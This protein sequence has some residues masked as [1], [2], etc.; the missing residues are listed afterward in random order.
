MRSPRYNLSHNDVE[1]W[2]GRVLPSRQARLRLYVNFIIYN[3]SQTWLSE[4]V[5]PPQFGVIVVTTSAGIMDHEDMRRKKTGGKV[6]AFF[7]SPA[8]RTPPRRLSGHA[9]PRGGGRD[10]QASRPLGWGS[11]LFAVAA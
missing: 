4:A 11:V 7:S 2:V 3:F 10:C 9:R 5:L 6:L 1:E 8:L